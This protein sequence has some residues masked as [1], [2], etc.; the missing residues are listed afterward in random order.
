M[1]QRRR[2]THLPNPAFATGQ[3]GAV[4][5]PAEGGSADFDPAKPDTHH[6]ELC[7][8]PKMRTSFDFAQDR[9]WGYVGFAGL[10]T[11]FFWP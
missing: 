9:F 2:W 10:P 4:S 7:S 3:V 5:R 8:P 11:P 6:R 1:R